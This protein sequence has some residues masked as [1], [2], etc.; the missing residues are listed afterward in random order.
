[1]IRGFQ[2]LRLSGSSHEFTRITNQ[3]KTTN[4]GPQTM[5]PIVRA[6][7]I[8]AAVTGA[9][10]PAGS[11]AVA[12]SVTAVPDLDLA[13]VDMASPSFKFAAALYFEALGLGDLEQRHP[14][15]NPARDALEDRC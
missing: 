11:R 8:A 6:A 12:R 9:R 14:R 13:G 4:H 1:M 2:S 15:I 3:T 10:T 5:L 7:A